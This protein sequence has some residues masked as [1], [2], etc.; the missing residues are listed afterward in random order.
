MNTLNITFKNNQKHPFHLV[1]PSPW[2]FIASIGVF[3]MA[4][5]FAM[6]MHQY[7][8]GFACFITGFSSILY[9]MFVWWRDIIRE[10]TFE[11][12]HTF[13]V[14]TGMRWGM[15]LFIISEIMFFFAFFWTF[16]HSSLSPAH[17]VGGI[18]PPYGISVLS[19]W[20]VPLIN[21]LI[22][23]LSGATVTWSHGAIVAGF[24]KSAIVS[25]FS[26]LY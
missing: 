19:P 3:S 16:F 13:V 11:G 7:S 25:L 8:G 9:I 12:Q 2:A 4:I 17:D 15:L 23:L 6:Y 20:E 22:L 18:Y 26:R 10:A 24:R 1:D 21:T 5:G 14:Q